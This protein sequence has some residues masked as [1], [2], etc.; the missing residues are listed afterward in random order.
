MDS[1]NRYYS[2]KPLGFQVEEGRTTFRVFSPRAREVILVIFCFDDERG[3]EFSMKRDPDGVWEYTHPQELW[4]RYYG[5]RVFGP[6]GP[7]EIFDSSLVIADPYSKAVVAKNTFCHEARSL[8]LNTDYDW[9]GDDFVRILPSDLIIYEMHLRDM[10]VHS[11][12]GISQPGYLGLT[13]EGKKGGLSYLKDLGV[14]A[15]ELFPCQHFAKM[16]IPFGEKLTRFG[17]PFYNVWN[18]YERNHWGYMTSYFFAP[19][20]YYAS[21][22]HLRPGEWMGG[23]GRQVREFKDMVKAVHR[24]GMAVILDVVY[25]HVSNYDNN[26]FKYLDKF[27][28]FPVKEDLTFLNTSGCGNDFY[29]GRP[30]VRRLIV[31]SIKHWMTEY[32]IDGFRFDL[33]HMID[34]ETLVAIT[35]EAR[36]INPQVLLIAEPWGGGGYDLGRF[37][38]LGWGAWNDVY[39]QGVKGKGPKEGRGLIFGE[40]MRQNRSRLPFFITG[41]LREFDGPFIESSH[42]VNY[43]ESHDGYTLGDFIRLATGRVSEGER[44]EDPDTIARLSP[45]ELK[46]HKLGALVLFLSQGMVMIHQGQEFGRSKVI[47]PTSAPDKKSGLLDENSYEKDNETNWINYRHRDVNLDLYGFYQGLI[48]L[49]KSHP[50]LRKSRP[51]QFHFFYSDGNRRAM[52]FLLLAEPLKD[53]D[54]L[55]LFNF[56]PHKKALFELGDFFDLFRPWSVAVDEDVLGTPQPLIPHPLLEL[57]PTSGALLIR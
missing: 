40:G 11:S 38:Q 3:E 15:L 54:F 26:S 45:K 35:E 31:D 23:E 18:P 8:I 14:N 20:P 13:E 6:Q 21:D 2:D 29:T 7:G 4:G 48:R 41:S 30:M 52:G 57:E 56:D 24:Q 10:T 28:Y 37:T 19:E 50:A 44:I 42:S 32:H 5:Y 27:Y 16:E 12:S 9:D 43:L 36:K 53:R 39:R 51:E 22:G 25:N 46:F 55:A 1:L 34:F 17:E 47:V 33:A 49:R